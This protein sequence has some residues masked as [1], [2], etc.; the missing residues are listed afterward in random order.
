MHNQLYL[1]VCDNHFSQIMIYTHK[2]ELF[3]Q[4][5]VQFFFF[6]LMIHATQY[7]FTN[8]THY[9]KAILYM[10][11]S[12]ITLPNTHT[13]VSLMSPCCLQTSSLPFCFTSHHHHYQKIW[14]RSSSP[15][16][17]G[18]FWMLGEFINWITDYA[19]LKPLCTHRVMTAIIIASPLLHWPCARHFR[20]IITQQES[21]QQ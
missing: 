8:T 9:I 20:G 4:E 13:N 7:I 17:S 19:A 18:I 10:F 3:W 15:I 5:R 14:D 12:H 1:H 11:P 6:S 2:W 16:C 21:W